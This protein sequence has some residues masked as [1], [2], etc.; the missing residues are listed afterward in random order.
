MPSSPI[1][2]YS[3]AGL[4][5]LV[6]ANRA[7]LF[8]DLMNRMAIERE[9]DLYLIEQFC[10]IVDHKGIG[11]HTAIC[12][13]AAQRV[14]SSIAFHAVRALVDDT[15]YMQLHLD[16]CLAAGSGLVTLMAVSAFHSRYLRA[17]A[18]ARAG[19]PMHIKTA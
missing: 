13:E 11:R 17:T 19:L 18:P 12:I 2:P 4:L 15:L 16:W 14:S 7:M 8:A 10:D 9:E 1:L 5:V 6:L 3:L